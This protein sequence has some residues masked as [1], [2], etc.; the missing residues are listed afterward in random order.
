MKTIDITLIIDVALSKT[1]SALMVKN[2]EVPNAKP[3]AGIRYRF[4][5]ISNPSIETSFKR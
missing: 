1:L 3:K 2:I 5:P 4:R